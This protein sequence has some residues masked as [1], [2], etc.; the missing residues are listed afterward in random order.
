MKSWKIGA[1]AGLIAGIAAGI[2][3][4]INVVFLFNIGH[5]YY[6]LPSPPESSTIY[7]TIV[8]LI[9]NIIWGIALGVFY[10]RI[11][12]LIPGKSDYKGL[13]YGLILWLILNVRNVTFNIIYEPHS[14][15]GQI[16]G[17]SIWIIYGLVLG[18][19]YEFL[20][21]KYHPVRK[22]LQISK[23]NLREGI[24][25]GAVAGLIGGIVISVA[26]ALLMDPLLFPDLIT[27]IGFLISQL[28]THTFIN[29]CWGVVFGILFVMFYKRIPGKKILK[30]ITFAM[31][32]FFITSFRVS[33]YWLSYGSIGG[34]VGWFN[35][36]FLFLIFGLIL[37]Y[38]Y[39]PSK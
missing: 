30:G 17:I 10:S 29:M 31:I 3:A 34:F 11:Y 28:G 12:D 26:H 16:L 32:I 20:K 1:I 24:H 18:I 4:I 33:L 2:I 8:E 9:I 15:F 27:D 25:P 36:I 5:S 38:F 21:S 6:D 39:K 37:G 22:K 13:F 14:I 7:I 23:Q 19:L 35:G